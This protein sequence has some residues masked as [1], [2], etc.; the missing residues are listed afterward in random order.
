LFFETEYI[1]HEVK[2]MAKH[3]NCMISEKTVDMQLYQASSEC[4]HANIFSVVDT[5]SSKLS[6]HKTVIS[7][8]AIH[9]SIIITALQNYLQ[10]K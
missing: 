1:K 8:N 7:V 10:P 4:T 2:S 3:H 9:Y 6:N 5:A